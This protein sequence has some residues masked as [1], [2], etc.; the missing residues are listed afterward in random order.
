MQTEIFTDEIIS[1]ICFGIT[2]VGG[3]RRGTDET[4]LIIT[5]F[6]KCWAFFIIKKFFKPQKLK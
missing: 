2:G 3:A 4:G 6:G 1:G 5:Y